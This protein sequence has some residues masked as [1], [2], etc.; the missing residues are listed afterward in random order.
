MICAFYIFYIDAIIING[1]KTTKK[2]KLLTNS[3]HN[4]DKG[5]IRKLNE[6]F[7]LSL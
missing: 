4:G 2:L 6:V 1:I 5:D 3:L 7:V